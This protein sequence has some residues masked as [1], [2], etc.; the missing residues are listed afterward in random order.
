MTI[1]R[2][3]VCPA[4]ELRFLSGRTKTFCPGCHQMVEPR[5]YAAG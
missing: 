4:C 2:I 1:R 3:V 5:E